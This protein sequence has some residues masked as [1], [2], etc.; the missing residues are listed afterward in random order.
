MNGRSHAPSSHVG[1]SGAGE[2]N[3]ERGTY[4]NE[5]VTIRLVVLLPI[6]SVDVSGETYKG[7]CQWSDTLESWPGPV[8]ADSRDWSWTESGK[9][10][11]NHRSIPNQ[12]RSRPY[13]G[14]SSLILQDSH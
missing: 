9:I 3:N 10:G 8:V 7:Q 13:F 2:I 1:Q 4:P 6:G 12:P 14:A 5:G 11:A